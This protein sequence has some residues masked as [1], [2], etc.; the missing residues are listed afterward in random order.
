MHGLDCDSISE[1]LFFIIEK[2]YNSG[3]ID[4]VDSL[5]KIWEK[6]CGII[7]PIERIKLLLSLEDNS[8]N[9]NMFS[10]NIIQN[11][12]IYRALKNNYVTNDT[13]HYLPF[14]Y[15]PDYPKLKKEFDIFSTK[16]SKKLICTFDTNT[17]ESL[18]YEFYAS[19][20][21]SLFLRLQKPVY[22]ETKL[23]KCYENYVYNTTRDSMLLHFGL[24]T[25][26]WVPIGN[27]KVLGWHPIAGFQFGFKNYD[28]WRL[29]LSMIIRFKDTK[30][31]IT[32]YF[33]DSLRTTSKYLGGYFGL[34]IEK[35]IY[36]D[37]NNELSLNGGFALDG[38]K[39]NFIENNIIYEEN[40]SSANLNFGFSYRRIL[41]Q[42]RYIEFQPFYNIISY[43]TDGG[44]NLE[45]HAI[46]FRLIFGF[47]SGKPI[48]EA[49]RSVLNYKY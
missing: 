19:T 5:L 22:K 18:L 29:D 13:V 31:P 23:K 32:L 44:T 2:E 16:I 40:L 42:K 10:D 26:V 39:S 43:K 3:N 34:N 4:S 30:E 27:N 36:A 47:L 38:F 7:E 11:L 46:S 25:G 6:N 21:D 37:I 49:K 41:K 15:Y 12:L 33:I 1:N 14:E 8:F 20:P 28:G 9:E 35:E 17:I 24:I 48:S 45:G